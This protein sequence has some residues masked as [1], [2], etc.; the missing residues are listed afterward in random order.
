MLTVN[1]IGGLICQLAYM[2]LQRS[3]KNYYLIFQ[4][5]FFRNK[6]R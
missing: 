5:N 1:V 4:S 6:V 3:L 2:T